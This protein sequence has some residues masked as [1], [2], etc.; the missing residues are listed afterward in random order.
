MP[1]YLLLLYDRPDALPADISPEEMQ[2]IIQKYVRWTDKLQAAGRVV[3]S[4]KLKDGEGRVLR[5]SGGKT[6]VKD[7]P[8]TETKEI[9]GGFQLITASSYDEA[10]K[11]CSDHPHLEFGT[12]EVREV[13]PVR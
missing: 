11:L 2:A 3:A 9:V 6:V 1:N 4:E 8:F 10:V 13:E 5:A 7:G 12:I